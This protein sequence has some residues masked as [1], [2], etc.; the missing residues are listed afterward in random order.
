MFDALLIPANAVEVMII[1]VVSGI[2]LIQL[3]RTSSSGV[4]PF[5][6]HGG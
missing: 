3:N 6:S 5:F 4:V 2:S 1:S